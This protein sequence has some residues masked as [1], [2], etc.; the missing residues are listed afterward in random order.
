MLDLES[1]TWMILAKLAGF[2]STGAK[3]LLLLKTAD[4]GISAQD[5][6]SA[7]RSYDQLQPSTAQRVLNFYRT[8][9]QAQSL[10]ASA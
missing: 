7:L 10:P 3:G 1:Q 6:D 8:R 9:L 2:S 4:R 5:L